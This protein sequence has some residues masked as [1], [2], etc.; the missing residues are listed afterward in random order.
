MQW[1]LSCPPSSV[2]CGDSPVGESL[3][4]SGALYRSR[5]EQGHGAD[6]LQPCI[7]TLISLL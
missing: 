3:C 1:G 6:C 2:R 7:F 5:A 4:R